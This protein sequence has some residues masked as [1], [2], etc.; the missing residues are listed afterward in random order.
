M[1]HALSA[2]LLSCLLLPQ[3]APPSP[4]DDLLQFVPDDAAFVVLAER[5]DTRMAA[6]GESPFAQAL[7]KTSL[8]GLARTKEWQELLKVQEYLRKNLDI[9]PAELAEVIP[10]ERMAFVYRMGPAD[11]PEQEQGMFLLRTRNPEALRKLLDRLN[12]AQKKAGELRELQTLEHLGVKYVRRVERTDTNFYLLRG[13]LLVFTGQEA[14]LKDAIASER[15]RKAGESG[16]FSKLRSSL[17]DDQSCVHFL[18]NARAFDE[19]FSAQARKDPGS[20][21]VADYW[22]ALEALYFSVAVQQDFTLRL[23]LQGDPR[24]LPAAGQRFFSAPARVSEV[25]SRMPEQ[26]LFAMGNRVDMASLY[27]MLGEFTPADLRDSSEKEL[28]R[29]VGALI[30]RGVVKEVLPAL[31]PDWGLYALAAPS[32]SRELFPR[33]LF[34][35]RLETSAIEGIDEALLDAVHAW[36]Q[37]AILA[38]NKLHPDQPAR[39]RVRIIDKVRVRVVEG[40]PYHL[41]PAYG[42]REGFLVVTSHADEIARF[43]ASKRTTPRAVPLLRLSFGG[44]R[45]HLTLRRDAWIDLLMRR[46]NLNRETATQR[47]DDLL[48][49]LKLLERLEL[50]HETA[51]GRA[52]FTLTLT[53]TLA[54]TREKASRP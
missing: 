37:L 30:G 13:S 27:A 16:R 12:E 38:H 31:G 54:L 23:H 28:E 10:G 44:W 33:L 36:T 15:D 48:A 24:K 46:D 11:K 53:P 2:L 42:L 32:D 40:L 52:T 26:T 18:L 50:T 25:W 7:R 35:M 3:A 43:K 19:T 47:L 49:G 21:T 39:S 6:L 8:P 14:I 4:R 5:L 22:K 41:L 17:R 20:K 45:E 29:T 34:A 51:P 9:D 1:P